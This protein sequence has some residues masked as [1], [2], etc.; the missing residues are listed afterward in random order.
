MKY[1]HRYDDYDNRP[2]RRLAP[3]KGLS[4]VVS[5]VLLLLG[6]FFGATALWVGGHFLTRMRNAPSLTNP[7][8]KQREA[9]PK[10]PLDYNETEAVE[11]FKK[12]KP[13]V[14]NV[15]LVQMKR[16]PWE[17]GVSQQQTSA[18]SGFI[19]DDDGRIVTNYH[20]IADM[21]TRPNMMVRIVMADRSAY[22]ATIVGEARDFD[23]AVL[24][25]APHNRPTLDKIKKIE[26]GTSHDLEV[27]QK[28]FAIGNPFGLS[29]TMTKGIISA[30]DRAIESPAKTPIP[31]I[32]Q[33]DAAIN[34]GNSGGPLLDKSGRLIGVNTAIA[35]A[36]PNGGNVGIGFAIPADTVNEVVTQIIQSGR[37]LR[38]DLGIKLFDERKLRHAR[39]D[40]GV[41]I[42]QTTPNGP[43][44]KAGLLGV[45]RIPGSTVVEPGD[46]ILAMSG[47][48]INSVDDYERSIRRLRPGDQVIVKI[49]RKEVEQEVTL[50]VGGA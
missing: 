18:G 20:V 32:I 33:V 38:P 45:R 21:H 30:L 7:D 26:L 43:A 24:Q 13:S 49:V 42:E 35:S 10:E 4:P 14:V 19:W 41:M 16:L 50:T 6:V 3:T 5:V 17:E 40:H 12:V 48:T 2:H 15:D 1:D 47:Q 28:A 27:G 39:Y 25:F 44:A 23:L 34:P 37:V 9:S 22:D 8:A 46:I 11:V 36:T 29:L 31:G